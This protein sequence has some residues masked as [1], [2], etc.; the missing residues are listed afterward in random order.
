MITFIL[1]ACTA[2]EKGELDTADFEDTAQIDDTEDTGNTEVTDPSGNTDFPDLQQDYNSVYETAL[3]APILDMGMGNITAYAGF[4]ISMGP[5]IELQVMVAS[6]GQ[7][8]ITC[9][10]IDGV[11]PS[12]GAPLEDV[13]VTGNGCVNDEGK[14]YDGSLVYNEAGVSYNSYTV[15]TPSG[16]ENCPDAFTTSIT[17]GGSRFDYETG[18]TPFIVKL[19]NEELGE[20]CTTSP[21]TTFLNGDVTIDESNIEESI[22]N[23]ELTFLLSSEQ[24]SMWFMAITEDEVL[25]SSVCES[26][27]LSGTNTM[28]NGEDDMV[29][30]FDGVTDC[31][32]EPTQLLSINGGESVEVQ[33]A[34]CSANSSRGG[35]LGMF[36][37][38]GL[39]LLRRKGDAT[40]SGALQTL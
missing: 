25:N 15:T 18:K 35:I 23:G 6:A 33:G 29:Y 3:P 8:N 31:D 21:S 30:T 34:S 9:P 14:S 7:E 2:T 19:Q 38:F 16:D 40:P 17:D 11:F 13:T 28:T 1:L 22:I 12:E 5:T 32:E 20:D 4:L 27:P 37:A 39:I 24:D 26:E 36:F 10:T